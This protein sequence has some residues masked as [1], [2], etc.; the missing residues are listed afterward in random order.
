MT[1][2]VC[3]AVLVLLLTAAAWSADPAPPRTDAYGDPLPPGVS[4]RIGTVRWRHHSTP[5]NPSFS[6]DGKVVISTD[7][8]GVLLWE[9][10]TGKRIRTITTESSWSIAVF[11]PD[12]RMV[13]IAQGANIELRDAES[14]KELRKLPTNQSP[15][16]DLEF[17]ADGQMLAVRGPQTVGVIELKTGSTLLTAPVTPSVTRSL[18]FSSDATL[19]ACCS[20]NTVQVWDIRN[21]ERLAALNA[22]DDVAEELVTRV[23]FTPDGRSLVVPVIRFERAV[24]RQNSTPIVR[25]WEVASG[26]PRL[27]LDSDALQVPTG[28]VAI[29]L[30]PDGRTL[31]FVGQDGRASRIS[32]WDVH[33][34][35]KQ[36]ERILDIPTSGY[37]FFSPDARTFAITK[38]NSLNLWDVATGKQLAAYPECPEG[39]FTNLTFAQSGAWLAAIG[40]DSMLRVFDAKTGKQLKELDRLEAQSYGISASPDGKLLATAG[41]DGFVRCYDVNKST[42]AWKEKLVNFNSTGIAFSPD[43]RLIASAH[44]RQQ[45]PAQPAPGN[46][47]P[48]DCLQLWDAT[49]GKQIRRIPASLGGGGGWVAFAADGASIYVRS[50]GDGGVHQVDVETGKLLSKIPVF[51][52]L[53]YTHL[54]PKHNLLLAG[55]N[56]GHVVFVDLKKGTELRRLEVTTGYPC[57][58]ALSPDGKYFAT[59]P[60]DLISRPGQAERKLTVR[61]L[62]TDKVVKTVDLPDDVRLTYLGFTPDGKQLVTATMN[63]TILFWDWVPSSMP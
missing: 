51:S 63:C 8:T 28:G 13:A 20:G 10:A 25:L 19:L 36:R 4:M 45:G 43:S 5:R 38:G 50:W 55:T 31:E 23:L 17:S 22:S 54:V 32:H 3:F 53:T 1:P 11:A 2:R 6:P 56:N 57:A 52:D 37:R 39:L 16:Y 14:G 29:A 49:T 15:V 24:G 47:E 41:Y 30:C 21:K 58:V 44:G 60:A 34:G 46:A 9:A 48:A 27:Q 42:E 59:G 18:A 7:G 62:A 12:G 61:E 26:K 33:T 40:S 35:K